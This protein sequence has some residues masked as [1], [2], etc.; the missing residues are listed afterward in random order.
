MLTF[1]CHLSLINAVAQ[2]Y[3]D[4]A[5]WHLYMRD[6]SANQTTKMN[7]ALALQIGPKVLNN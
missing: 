6:L 5:G 1:M 7:Q 2:V 4:I 3:I